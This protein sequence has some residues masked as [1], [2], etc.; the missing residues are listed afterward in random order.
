MEQ[1][2]P[3]P[4]TTARSTAYFALGIFAAIL[5]AYWPPFY[6]MWRKWATDPQY[7]QGYIV[8]L[9]AAVLVWLR[10]DE[11]RS[12]ECQPSW[13]GALFLL[14]GVAVRLAGTVLYNAWLEGIS[15]LPVLWG[16]TLLLA[17]WR[18]LACTWY[19]V[20]F[21]VFMIP[22]P[23]RVET[24]LSHPLQRLATLSSTYLL[25]TLG[26]PAFAEGNVI[27][28]NEERIGIIEACNGLGMLMLFFALAVAMAILSDRPL[29][30]RLLLVVAAVPIAVL[31]N[32]IRI[33]ATAIVSD[34]ISRE[35]A[36][37]IFHDLGGWLMMPLAL[38]MLWG[39]LKLFDLI[40]ITDRYADEP[41]EVE[42][43]GFKV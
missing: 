41:L 22:L 3:S 36:D 42:L 2:T 20:A 25:Q 18:G 7:S 10:R 6:E 32:T 43:G 23:Y 12:D 8:P 33:S 37:K 40:I 34:T 29:I 28:L 31:A 19:A 9:F 4:A 13:W 24:G 30:D 38:G 27:V 1:T 26:F 35:L 11:L 15:L 14:V 39:F 5:W 16:V 21:L 17:G